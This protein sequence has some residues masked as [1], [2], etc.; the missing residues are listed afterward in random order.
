VRSRAT[1][2]EAEL[3]TQRSAGELY[4]AFAGLADLGL[5]ILQKVSAAADGLSVQQFGENAAGWEAWLAM[6]RLMRAGLVGE[7][8]RIFY[9]TGRGETLLEEL[10]GEESGK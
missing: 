1:Q 9:L 8:G 3:S 2:L 7:N 10:T 5:F 4:V 6:C